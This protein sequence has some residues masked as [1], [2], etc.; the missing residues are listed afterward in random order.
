MPCRE[1]AICAWPLGWTITSPSQSS[2][3]NCQRRSIVRDWRGARKIKSKR[4]RDNPPYL[5]SSASLA[6]LTQGP[7]EGIGAPSPLRDAAS[8]VAEDR[9]LLVEGVDAASSFN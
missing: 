1:T 9:S 2:S 8:F 4:V 7:D 5:S 6:A 3:R